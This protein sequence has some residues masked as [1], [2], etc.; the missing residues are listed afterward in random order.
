MGA[1]CGPSR[2]CGFGLT[3]H[4]LDSGIRVKLLGI[5]HLRRLKP[6]G[7]ISRMV[8]FGFLVGAV[9][10]SCAMAMD[11]VGGPD[12]LNP[13]AGRV[14]RLPPVE[15]PDVAVPTTD[16]TD[17]KSLP[18]TEAIDSIVVAEVVAK[19]V[20]KPW[21]ASFEVGIDGSGGNS[22]TFN[23]RFGVDTQLKT[24]R[25]VLEVDFDYRKNTADWRE[26]ANRAFLDWECK[27]L[28]GESPWSAFVHGTVEYDEFRDFDLRV[29][30]DIGISREL[31]DSEASSLSGRF[32]GGFSRELGLPSEYYVPELVFGLDFTHR[33]SKRQKLTAKIDYMPDVTAFTDFRINTEA[34]WEVVIDQD[35]NLT[36]KTSMLNRYDSTPGTSKSNDVDY[37]IVLLWSF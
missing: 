11:A 36:L 7:R 23:F 9:C 8:G 1:V 26:T 5:E 24:S 17:A 30:A 12:L 14:V 3:G 20:E 16:A 25:C 10:V 34:A 29:A 18:V 37:S 15:T 35:T 19:P 33:L 13:G 27:R 21:E 4:N 32:G 22:E 6:A 2:W 31:L 28:F